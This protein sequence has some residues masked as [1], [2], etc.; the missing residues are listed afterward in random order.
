MQRCRVQ[1]WKAFGCACC[2]LFAT[3]RHQSSFAGHLINA[4]RSPGIP[5]GPTVAKS[6]YG[7]FTDAR[8]KAELSSQLAADAD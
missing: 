8:S 2:V 7:T 4:V 3:E 5:L 6:L 1:T